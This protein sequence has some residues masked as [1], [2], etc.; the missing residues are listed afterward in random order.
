MQEIFFCGSVIRKV[1][2]PIEI[3][4]SFFVGSHLIDKTPAAATATTAG[5]VTPKT[6]I[7]EIATGIHQP[8]APLLPF[9]LLLLLLRPV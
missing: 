9:P 1:L 2:S 7:W 4:Y 6:K 5:Q 3:S 8:L